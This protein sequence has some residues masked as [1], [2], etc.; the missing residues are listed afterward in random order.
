MAE[1]VLSKR[2]AS[3][4]MLQYMPKKTVET[5]IERLSHTGDRLLSFHADWANPPEYVEWLFSLLKEKGF[6]TIA[7]VQATDD[8]EIVKRLQEKVD[9]VEVCLERTNKFIDKEYLSQLQFP[10]LFLV[11]DTISED[12]LLYSD[13]IDAMPQSSR[14][15]LGINWKNR[16]SG[17]S[18]FQEEDWSSWAATIV[19]IIEK[20]S[21]KRIG[22]EL[23]CGIKLC[24]FNRQQLG[25]LPTKLIKWPLAACHT[26]F[27]FDAD[28]NLQPCMRLS[29]PASLNFN[30]ESDLREVSKS[31]LEWLEPYNGRCLD[32]EDLNCRSHKVGCC[33][34]GCIEHTINEWQAS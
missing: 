12:A 33:G 6:Q 1:L 15:T 16:L 32:A 27:F 9:T 13:I 31:F 4:A 23:A 11:V 22:A 5:I 28:G 21:A 17:P 14:V 18:V 3:T 25:I 2:D 20:L 29:L 10:R 19:A 26:S 24:M 30:Y 7:C 8:V 34:T